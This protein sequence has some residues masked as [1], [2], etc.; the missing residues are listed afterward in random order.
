ARSR[1]REPS[2]LHRP[3][4]EAAAH[5]RAETES[6]GD[7]TELSS[8]SLSLWENAGALPLPLGEG[9]VRATRCHE[10]APAGK[11]PSPAL[12]AV[13]S[14]PRGRGLINP[15]GPSVGQTGTLRPKTGACWMD[16]LPADT[17]DSPNGYRACFCSIDAAGAAR[18]F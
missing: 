6:A 16:I 14:T 1:G 15:L 12:R 8:H 2:Q 10:I 13:S 18:G 4:L 17:G 3:A 11:Q 5:A 7:R 9:G